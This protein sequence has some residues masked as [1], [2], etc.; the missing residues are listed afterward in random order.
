[1]GYWEGNLGC[2]AVKVRPWQRLPRQAVA[3]PSLETFKARGLEQ[4][5]IVQGVPS[6]ETRLKVP[7]NPNHHVVL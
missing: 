4:S 3:T 5:G 7:S 6:T 1:M 2:E